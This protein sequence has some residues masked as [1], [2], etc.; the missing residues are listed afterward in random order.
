MEKISLDS[1]KN[2]LKDLELVKYTGRVSQ[3]IGLTIESIGPSIKIGEVCKIY[4]LKSKKIVL[5]EVVGFKERRVLLMPLGEME[6]IGPGSKV[7][8]TGFQL[9]VKVGECLLGR[10]L[11]GLGNTIDEKGHLPTMKTYPVNAAPPNPLRRTKI[12]EPLSLGIKAIDGLLTCGNGQRLGIFSGSGVGKSTLLGAIARNTQAD[13]NV[14]A[15]IGERGREV[16]EFLEN[17]L[18]EEGLKKSVVIIATSDQPAL[19]RMKGALLATSIA[20]YFRDQG[21]NVLLLMDSLTRFSMALREIGL[22]IGEPPVTKGYTPSVFAVLPKLLER[23]GTSE[24]GSITG[25]YTV[26][27]DGDDMND[28]IADA[29]R[30]ILDGHIVLSRKLANKNHYPAIDILSSISRIM[31][32]ISSKEHVLNANRIKEVLAEYKEAE[33]LINIGAYAKGSNSRIDYAIEKIDAINKLLKQDTDEKFSYN[34]TVD[35]IKNMINE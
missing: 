1:F 31:P 16:N 17:D 26:L 25:L 6:G 13:V 33:D 29:V 5:A 4:T 3:I 9:Q 10:V 35:I 19:V 8:A 20:E 22:A 11:D 28:P 7:E 21:K 32:N 2:A 24:K 14:I 18:K 15:L 12:T 34:E 30:G 23:S 27:V